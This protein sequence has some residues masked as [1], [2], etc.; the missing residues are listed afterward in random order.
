MMRH[1]LKHLLLGLLLLGLLTACASL[2]E[3]LTLIQEFI[4]KAHTPKPS[5]INRITVSGGYGGDLEGRHGQL[6]TS[7]GKHYTSRTQKKEIS[8]GHFLILWP[9][10][11]FS[12]YRIVSARSGTH[13]LGP[14]ATV[15]EVITY[16]KIQTGTTECVT[17]DCGIKR[18]ALE[19][20]FHVD[21]HTFTIGNQTFAREK[22][23]LFVITFDE[24]FNTQARQAP[25]VYEEITKTKEILK[26]Y[27][28]AL[29]NNKLIQSLEI[30]VPI[31]DGK[32]KEP[33]P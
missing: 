13:H 17:P 3:R 18:A 26:A 25:K 29:P 2:G 15:L 19:A 10:L 9:E 31:I 16:Q 32:P 23:N 24:N 8:V 5:R 21:D 6:T 7:I 33:G 14:Y 20:K 30:R 1:K 22:G 12:K 11:D 4:V 27:K 28:A